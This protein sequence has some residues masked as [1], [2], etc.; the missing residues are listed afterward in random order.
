M[1]SM[2]KGVKCRKALQQ[3]YCTY[4]NNQKNKTQC[5]N[6]EKFLYT[7]VERGGNLFER[8]KL[9]N[10]IPYTDGVLKLYSQTLDALL[11]LNDRMKTVK[12]ATPPTHTAVGIM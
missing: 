2:K 10:D 5:R 1:C 4:L 11:E 9:S 8:Q 3:Y 6:Q 12:A 7:K